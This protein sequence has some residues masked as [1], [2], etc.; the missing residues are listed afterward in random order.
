MLYGATFLLLG[1]WWFRRSGYQP[2]V[3]YLYPFV[4]VVCALAA[5]V[6]PL[7]QFLLWLGPWFSKGSNAEWVMLGFHL[8]APLLLLAIVW[9]R[10]GTGRIQ[11]PADLPVL[12]IPVIFHAFDIACAVFGGMWEVLWLVAAASVVEVGAIG[13]LIWMGRE[14]TAAPYPAQID[15]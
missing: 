2:V 3:G 10:R 9:R 5:M 6:S 12:A 11:F 4:A 14:H 1:R 7:S 15:P 8:C 13:I